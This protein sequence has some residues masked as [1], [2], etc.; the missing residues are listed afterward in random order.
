MQERQKAWDDLKK[1]EDCISNLLKQVADH[2]LFD[3]A[4]LK[5]S[6]KQEKRATRQAKR[7]ARMKKAEEKA[8]KAA[9]KAA[10]AMDID[11]DDD[12][13]DESDDS[14]EDD[15]DEDDDD[16]LS[17][18]GDDD[19]AS[20][21]RPHERYSKT[22][23]EIHSLCAPHAHW[24][25]AYRPLNN[26][27]SNESRK[28]KKPVDSTNATISMYQA[29]VEMRLAQ[30]KRNICQEWLRLE[31]Q[32]MAKLEKTAIKEGD[33]Q[34]PGDGDSKKRKLGA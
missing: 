2:G 10:A 6:Q 18:E 13:G 15:M 19:E 34:P 12:E 33:V 31:Q 27:L 30:E 22:L 4:S 5:E 32:E 11:D 17:E 8:A 25:Q 1:A 9:A 20:K 3:P 29:R 26:A 14:D 28:D 16:S 24:I 7:T 21:G 23:Q